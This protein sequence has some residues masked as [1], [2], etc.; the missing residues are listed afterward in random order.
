MQSMFPLVAPLMIGQWKV[1]QLDVGLSNGHVRTFN[2]STLGWIHGATIVVPKVGHAP[3]LELGL[4][5]Q[6]TFTSK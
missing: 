6:S 3:R 1:W 4:G 2:A 5:D